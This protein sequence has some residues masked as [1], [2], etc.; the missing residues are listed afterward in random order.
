MENVKQPI[1]GSTPPCVKSNSQLNASITTT[2][3]LCARVE[4]PHLE[5]SPTRETNGDTCTLSPCWKP[6]CNS[7]KVAHFGWPES[8]KRNHIT[9]N[10][11]E[12]TNI[13]GYC[14]E[15]HYHHV[16]VAP[17]QHFVVNMNNQKVS[18]SPKQNEALVFL[19]RW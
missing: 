2:K 19:P 4:K 7:K 1:R 3:M 12:E 17:Q 14:H 11:M 18:V 5:K 9:I 13:F 6:L 8:S 16:G 15:S 10:N